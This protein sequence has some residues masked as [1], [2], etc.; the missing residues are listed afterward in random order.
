MIRLV[1]IMLLVVSCTS[2]PNFASKSEFEPLM[3]RIDK[4][5]G[6]YVKYLDI[7]P[8]SA[9]EICSDIYKRK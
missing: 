8:K 1:I 5:V 4:C 6:R 7:S 3:V 9:H 2:V